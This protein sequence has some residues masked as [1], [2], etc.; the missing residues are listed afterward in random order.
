MPSYAYNDGDGLSV[1]DKTL[2]NGATEPVS[3]LDD[4]LKQVK[5]WM[6]DATAGGAKLVADNTSYGT[7]ITDGETAITALQAADVTQDAATTNLTTRVT[8]LETQVGA[9]VGSSPVTA[10]VT[11][12]S[13]QA[14]TS[15]AGATTVNFDTKSIDT[16]S[17]F[18]TST[19]TFTA[20]TAGL[21]HVIVSLGLTTSAS[22]TPTVLKHNLEI[23]IAGVSAAKVVLET[24]TDTEDRTIE[25]SRYFQLSASQTILIKYNPTTG[26]GTMTTTLQ[27]ADATKTI[28]QIAR[29]SS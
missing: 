1:I 18:S 7:R 8:S 9:I 22:S 2:P 3:N 4:A 16:Y 14:V 20:P 21:Y 12:G 24:G 17:A 23:F 11:M 10:I 13:T 29:I 15:A 26:S 27:Y 19:K 25:I 5:A 28:L 6:K